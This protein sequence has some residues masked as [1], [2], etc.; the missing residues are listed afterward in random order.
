MYMCV[1]EKIAIE[2]KKKMNSGGAGQ[3]ATVLN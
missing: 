2:K 3:I 1:V